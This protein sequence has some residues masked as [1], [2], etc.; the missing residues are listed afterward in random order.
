MKIKDLAFF[1]IFIPA[2]LIAHKINIFATVEGN[3]IYTQ[4]YASDGGKIKAGLIEVYD[5][6][7]NK[8]LTGQTDSLGEFSFPIPKRDD[9]K[10]VV[11]G[12]MGHRAE[13]TISSD[14]L[15]EIKTLPAPREKIAI[16]KTETANLD[17]LLLKRMIEDAVG[18]QLHPV[19]KMLAEQRKERVSFTEVIG[20]IGYILGIIGIGMFF[21][22]RKKNV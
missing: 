22:S 14:D 9:L 12:G 6:A 3:R 13:T 17:T 2:L 10:I 11:I 21:L 18:N 1:A 16:I 19:V 8:L 5:R 20:G 4:S 15:P 7:G